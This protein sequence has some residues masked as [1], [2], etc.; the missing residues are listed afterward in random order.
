MK[1]RGSPISSYLSWMVLLFLYR[2][3]K[4]IIFS[5]F[6]D[7]KWRLLLCFYCLLHS[8]HCLTPTSLCKSPTGG[9]HYPFSKCCLP[10]FFRLFPSI[11]QISSSFSLF[12]DVP[13]KKE[14]LVYSFKSISHSKQREINKLRG[15][16]RL[17]KVTT[18]KTAIVGE[19]K[20]ARTVDS[21]KQSKA[22]HWKPLFRNATN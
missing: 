15:R 1:E 19:N 3:S 4:G 2:S 22:E 5:S 17:E 8:Q 21:V 16:T 10:C 6:K 11:L 9:F 7:P 12:W 13:L 14:K 18:P 20:R